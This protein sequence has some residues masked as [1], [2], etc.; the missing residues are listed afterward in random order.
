MREMLLAGEKTL[1]M[2]KLFP[3]N[4][5]AFTPAMAAIVLEMLTSDTVLEILSDFSEGRLIIR[6][7]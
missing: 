7:T 3:L 1:L 2:S 6:G 4:C 5:D